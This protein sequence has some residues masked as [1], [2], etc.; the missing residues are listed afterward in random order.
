MKRTLGV[1]MVVFL[2]AVAVA[3]AAPQ[4]AAAKKA[5]TARGTVKMVSASSLTITSGGKDMMFDVDSS[6]KVVAKGASTKTAAAKEAGKSLAITDV[7][8]EKDR[9]TVSYHDMGGGKMHAASVR[10]M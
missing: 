2:F 6:T 10:V 8:K 9:V 3:L 4:K 1:S 7:V 5:M